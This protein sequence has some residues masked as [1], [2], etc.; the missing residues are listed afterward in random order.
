MWSSLKKSRIVFPLVLAAGLSAGCTDHSGDQSAL[1][2]EYQF[3]RERRLAL[4]EAPS[5]RA[6]LP[7]ERIELTYFNPWVMGGDR[8]QFSADGT[9]LMA[10]RE[11]YWKGTVRLFKFG[12]L[13]YLLESLGFEEMEARY[14]GDL[15]DAT[16]VTM[17]AWPRGS[18]DPVEVE[19]YAGVAPLEFQTLELAINGVARGLDWKSVPAEVALAEWR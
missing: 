15:F 4:D 5:V 13:C 7:Y 2:A 16:T 17:Q 8:I 11:G 9:A 6:G 1:P 10:N 19:D 14:S 3:L 12:H 18:E